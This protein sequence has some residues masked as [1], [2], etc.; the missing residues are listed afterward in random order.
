MTKA[1]TI[2]AFFLFLAGFLFIGES[3][4]F[5][6][7]NFQDSYVQ[8]GYFLETGDSED[9]MRSAILNKANEYEALVFTIDKEDGGAFSRKVIVYGNKATQKI[10]KE[11]WSIE[12]GTISS[13]FSGKTTFIFKPFEET[14]E[15]ELQNCWYIRQSSEQLYTM[16]F[17]GMVKYSGNFRNDP[18]QGISEKVVAALWF[19]LILI[20]LLLTY[21]DTVYSKKE[22]MVRMVLG[23]DLVHMLTH[24]IISDTV[25]FSLAALAAMML[26]LPFTN[27]LFRWNISVIGFLTLILSNGLV[28][29]LGMGIEKQLQIKS[30]T[31]S[32]KALHI[33]VIIKGLVSILTVLVLSVTIYLSV[34]GIKLYKQKNYYS[35][36]SNM[37]HV[38][39]AYPY[40]YEKMEFATGQFES[41][42]PLDTWKQ[43]RDNFMRYSY[44]ELRC[45]LVCYQSFENVSPK[46]GDRYVFAN[47][48]GLA[49]YSDM[50]Q[51]WDG[52]CQKEGNYILIPDSANQ[53]EIVEEIMEAS[54]LLGLD[55]KNLEGVFTYKDGLSVIAEGHIDNEFDYSYKIKNPVIILDTYN[56][57]A[58]PVYPVSYQLR[59]ADH[60]DGIIAH[61]FEYLMQ[62]V[63]LENNLEKI[64][65]FANAISG[66]AINPSLVEFTVINLGNWFDGLWSLQNRSLLIAVILTLLI[67]ILEVQISILS[68]RM[69]YETNA[70]ELTIKKVMG[71]SVFE[72]FKLFFLLTCILCGFSLVGAFICSVI[73]KT[74]MIGYLILGSII[75]FL[76]DVG[77]LLYLTRKNDN[78]QIQKVLKGGI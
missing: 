64:Y 3:Y 54:N 18:V 41:M 51:G 77:I 63:A 58:L 53:S 39:V 11:D 32:K 61:N 6:L 43:L 20:I 21:Y 24:K 52:L 72:R 49:Q 48:S 2:I 55:E 37:V 62:F 60:P 30:V 28:I 9:G 26:L 44:N 75:V 71:Y 1:K 25:G 36:Q 8:V 70:R 10:L 56:Y 7:E 45:S 27:P 4:T 67:L 65:G 59:E 29:A 5:F 69:S 23:A 34:E 14:T 78:L 42:P 33:S 76:L 46:W 31:S 57:G 73:F 16:L 17:P 40:D 47:L 66:E 35:T 74:S 50:I 68:L 22:Q 15:K 13:F 38:D 19:V 12:E